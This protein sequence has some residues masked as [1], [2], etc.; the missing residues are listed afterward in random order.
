M[1]TLF[2]YAPSMITDNA[3]C[4]LSRHYKRQ[5]VW[6]AGAEP[7]NGP[8]SVHPLMALVYARINVL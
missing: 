1:A 5:L 2:P 6:T 3:K 4:N 8:F 7:A